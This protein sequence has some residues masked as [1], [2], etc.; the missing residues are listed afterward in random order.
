MP[1]DAVGVTLN[2][3]MGP[4]PDDGATDVL[5]SDGAADMRPVYAASLAVK[6]FA[7][8]PTVNVRVGGFTDKEPVETLTLTVVVPPSVSLTVMVA[9]PCAIGVTLKVA[10]GPFP[11]PTGATVATPG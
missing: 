6:G 9:A 2:V 10:L 4:L 7:A 11:D 5:E 3:A 1:L 8:P